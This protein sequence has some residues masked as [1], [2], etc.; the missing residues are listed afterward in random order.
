MAQQEA[1]VKPAKSF[2]FCAK[3]RQTRMI[4]VGYDVDT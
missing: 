1:L 2:L 3:G 4:G